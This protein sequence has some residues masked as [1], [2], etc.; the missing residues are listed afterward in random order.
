MLIY[1]AFPEERPVTYEI[2]ITPLFK[3]RPFLS[4]CNNKP[5]LKGRPMFICMAL[6]EER[7]IIQKI[8]ISPLFKERPFL[9]FLLKGLPMLIYIAFSDWRIGSSS[10]FIY[11]FGIVVADHIHKMEYALLKGW[12]MLIYI[13]CSKRSSWHPRKFI[14][15]K[16]WMPNNLIFTLNIYKNELK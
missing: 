1:M 13:H 9:S 10:T 4:F 12:Q 8:Y 14:F 11:T 2:Y 3:D 7:P 5:L 16:Y 15:K 6:Q